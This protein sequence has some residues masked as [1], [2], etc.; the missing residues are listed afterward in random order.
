[1]QIAQHRVGSPVGEDRERV[2]G[3]W[4]GANLGTEL[5]ERR[6]VELARV[7]VVLDDEDRAA[8]EVRVTQTSSVSRFTAD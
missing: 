2:L 4:R 5:R 3:G 1:V 8:F 6:R 7:G